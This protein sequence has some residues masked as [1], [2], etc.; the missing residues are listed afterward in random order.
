MHQADYHRLA[1]RCGLVY[2]PGRRHPSYALSIHPTAIVSRD[3]SVSPEAEVGPYSVIVG[4]VDIGP[5]TVV[6]SHVR[7][8]SPYGEVVIGA[9]NYIQSG[10]SLGAPPQDWSYKSGYTH[11]IIGDH[12]RFGEGASLNLGSKEGGGVTRVG[13]R[14]FIMANAHVGHDCQIGDDVVLTNLAQLAGHVVVERNVVIGGVAAV[15]QFV[16]L[17][18][19]SFLAAGAFANKDILPYT[20]AEGH[21]AAPRALNRVGLSR[22]GVSE[23]ERRN[24]D[25]AIRILLKTSMTVD[26]A[27]EKIEADC[28]SDSRIVHL[29]GFVSGSDRGDARG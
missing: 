3:A 28:E 24:L 20:I 16:R 5:H 27:L 11:L 25:R 29:M 17:G 15:T 10:A 6:E 14:V 13:D 7:L 26:E 23:G 2:Q 4:K 8:G 22:A 18:E 12:N 19:F 21:W 1:G 9:H